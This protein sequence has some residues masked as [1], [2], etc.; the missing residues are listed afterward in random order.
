MGELPG[1][2]VARDAGFILGVDAA[3][4]TLLTQRLDGAIL[5]TR[6]PA[7]GEPAPSDPIPAGRTVAT[8][9][10]YVY[11]VTPSPARAPL[12]S[13]LWL[14]VSSGAI[15]RYDDRAGGIR[16]LGYATPRATAIGD[17]PDAGDVAYADATGVI[18]RRLGGQVDRVL[19]GSSGTS[20]EDLSVAPDGST[21]LLCTGER[22]AVLDI[23]KR[24]LVAD[25]VADG[26]SRF[27]TWD[28][29]GSV[30]AWTFDRLGG[31]EGQII[32]R[33][34]PL[35]TRVAEA[36]SNLRVESRRLVAK[37]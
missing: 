21:M 19:E 18:I 5:A 12:G 2:A 6:I 22:I 31:A 32:P 35:A 23:G 33:G 17:G 9:D 7:P 20:W 13:G 16:V 14:A 3:C 27:S 1:A 4:S 36:A 34:L 28:A 26:R 10:G 25:I 24:E 29:E 15:A 8:A 30:L 11:A 37:P